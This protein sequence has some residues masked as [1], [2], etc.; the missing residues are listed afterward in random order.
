MDPTKPVEIFIPAAT[1]RE[2]HTTIGH[3]KTMETGWR[4]P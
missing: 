2:N 4:E 1:F 3:H